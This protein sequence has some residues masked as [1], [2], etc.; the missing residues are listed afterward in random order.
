MTQWELRMVTVSRSVD[1][2]DQWS[3]DYKLKPLLEDGWEPFAVEAPQP[4]YVTYHFRRRVVDDSDIEAA[5][6]DLKQM[7]S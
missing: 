3:I 1:E 4:S 7:I 6:Q 5:I 2:I